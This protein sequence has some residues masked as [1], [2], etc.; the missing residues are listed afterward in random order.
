MNLDH[1]YDVVPIRATFVG[2][3]NAGRTITV[4]ED[5]DT[6]LMPVEEGTTVEHLLATIDRA[7]AGLGPRDM[8]GR[9]EVYRRIMV[10][11]DGT[12]VYRYSPNG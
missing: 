5:R 12:R 6:L 11:D 9:I 1:L 2:G 8:T 7:A 10:R 4:A 3:V